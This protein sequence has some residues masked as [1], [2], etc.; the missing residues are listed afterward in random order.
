[1]GSSP[2][3]CDAGAIGWLPLS[4]ALLTAIP[5]SLSL[6]TVF[7]GAPLIAPSIRRYSTATASIAAVVLLVAV[8]WTLLRNATPT[9][10]FARNRAILISALALMFILSGTASLGRGAQKGGSRGQ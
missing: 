6:P 1:M 4:A 10:V 8:S 2:P 5:A 3:A 7:G 9:A